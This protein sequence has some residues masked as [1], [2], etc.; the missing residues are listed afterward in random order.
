MEKQKKAAEA[1]KKT[2]LDKLT[3]AETA[4]EKA[5]ITVL[6]RDKALD[7]LKKE[8]AALRAEDSKAAEEFTSLQNKNK[9]LEEK[10]SALEAKEKEISKI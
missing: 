5:K 7:A 9:L 4:F 10:I 3:F 6:E 1:A 2:A 8:V